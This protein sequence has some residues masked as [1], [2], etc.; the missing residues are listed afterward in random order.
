MRK[1]N[2]SFEEKLWSEGYGK[3]GQ[4][5]MEDLT[6]D[7]DAVQAEVDEMD[8]DFI[9]W[10][11]EKES[12]GFVFKNGKMYDKE[13]VEVGDEKD[14]FSKSISSTQEGV[15]GNGEDAN[16]R[17]TG[18]ADALPIIGSGMKVA[19]GVMGEFDTAEE[20]A[21]KFQGQSKLNNFSYL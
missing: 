2:E 10:K 11:Q 13:G 8:T 7:A 3:G 12:E 20:E 15:S 6:P 4:E 17:K 5:E 21:K 19:T 18:F 16:S 14:T 1:G 9:N